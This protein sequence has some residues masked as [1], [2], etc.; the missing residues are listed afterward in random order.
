[1][2][3]QLF[4]VVATSDVDWLDIEIRVHMWL[5]PILRSYTSNK[6]L[7]G[8]STRTFYIIYILYRAYILEF[9]IAFCTLTIVERQLLPCT[10]FCLSL[11]TIKVRQFNGT[12]S[13]KKLILLCVAVSLTKFSRK[14]QSYSCLFSL[15]YKIRDYKTE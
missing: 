1:M 2:T 5:K 13:S 14:L 7:C 11:S 15:G 8:I 10:F 4:H 9:L 12:Y 3:A 6:S